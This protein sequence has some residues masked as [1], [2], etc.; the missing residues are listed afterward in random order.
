M[1]NVINYYYNINP[2]NIYQKDKY[3]MFSYNDENYCFITYNRPFEEIKG[4]YE[5]NLQM[6]NSNLLVHEIILN[7]D[8]Y[9]ITPMDNI[10]YVL[11]KVYVNVNKK[12]KLMDIIEINNSTIMIKY[13][14]V[15]NRS[16]WSKLWAD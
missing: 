5:L 16:N 14:S 1:K 4:L 9:A 2:S 13:D 11:L 3:F 8:G 6:L 10:S 15:L 12:S 7:K